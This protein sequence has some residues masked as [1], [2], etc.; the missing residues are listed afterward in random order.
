MRHVRK[1]NPSMP[2]RAGSRSS[3][4]VPMAYSGCH[5][6]AA[7]PSSTD[8]T[9]RRIE[10]LSRSP[11]GLV[12]HRNRSPT[13][14][15]DKPLFIFSLRSAPCLL[16]GLGKLL[17]RPLA[18]RPNGT[19]QRQTESPDCHLPSCAQAALWHYPL[20]RVNGGYPTGCDCPPDRFFRREGVSTRAIQSVG[21]FSVPGSVR[22]C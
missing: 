19:D 4:N 15:R 16:R 5:C 1:S 12:Y 17:R 7:D 22:S 18:G 8:R 11:P 9:A 14:L 20:Y 10:M 2:P 21:P 13:H 6:R 3:G